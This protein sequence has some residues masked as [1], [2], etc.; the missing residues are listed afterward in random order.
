MR[1]FN[2][3]LT[4]I[5]LALSLSGLAC[6]PPRPT[7]QTLGA[8]AF[9]RCVQC[10]GE[11]G[12]GKVNALAPAIAGQE[13]WY[14]KEQLTK[15]QN[16]MRGKHFDDL[17]G[18]RMR[19]MSLALEEEGSVEAV[20]EYVAALPD[21]QPAP[22]VEGGKAARGKGLYGTCAACHG[23]KGEGNAAQHAPS[24]VNTNDWY[25][26]RSLQKFKEHVRGFDPKDTWGKAMQPMA[27][28][29]ADEQAMKDVVAYIQ[30][31]KD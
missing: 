26:V 6:D 25:L 9:T 29:L 13:A 3:T 30:T 12:E 24:L 31:L 18:L 19:P 22:I 7:E 11:N 21:V 2:P 1:A 16:G 27:A 14:I 10:H 28:T 20:A 4:G 15:Y 8:A 23:Q 5:A 17:E